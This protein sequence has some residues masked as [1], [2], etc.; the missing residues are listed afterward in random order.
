MSTVHVQIQIAAPPRTVWD[1]IMD[2][3]KLGQWVT[4]HRSVNVRSPDPTSEGAKMD[5]VLH[6]IGF[7]FK[8]HWTLEHVV[9]AREAEWHG[10]GP[11]LSRAMIRYRLKESGAGTTFDYFN[12]FHT[13]GGAVGNAASRMVVGHVPEREAQD[14]LARLKRLIEDD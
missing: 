5:Q 9:V 4:I 6:M 13:P 11:A 14:S 2:P 8:V 10:R 12:E 7:S 1:T 3:D